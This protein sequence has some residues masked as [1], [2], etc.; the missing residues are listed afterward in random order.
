MID[1][2]ASRDAGMAHVPELASE[3]APRLRLSPAT[4]ETYL[5]KN[6]HYL[7]DTRAIAGVE[8][9]FAEGQALGLLPPTAALNWMS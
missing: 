7:L 8:R 4:V 5:T 1:L 6:I 9:F 3:W 2:Q